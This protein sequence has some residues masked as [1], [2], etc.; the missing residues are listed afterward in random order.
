MNSGFNIIEEHLIDVSSADFVADQPFTF[1]TVDG[2][3]VSYQPWGNKDD[4]DPI[5]KTIAASDEFN[6]VVQ[7]KKIFASG[8][9]ATNIYVGYYR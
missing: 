5:T 2:G 8:T 1:H 6:R 4:D 7:C 9:T 3:D